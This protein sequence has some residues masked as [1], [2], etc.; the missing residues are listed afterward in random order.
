VIAP[1][2]TVLHRAYGIG[3]EMLPAPQ[4][5]LFES[6]ARA[7]FTEQTLPWRMVQYGAAIGIALLDKDSRLM[8]SNPALQATLGYTGHELDGMALSELCH[9][10]DAPADFDPCSE[11]IAGASDYYRAEKRFDRKD[12]RL[13]WANVTA[14]LVRGTG[15]EPQFVICMVEDITQ[16][17]Q[18]QAALLRAERLAIAGKLAASLAHEINNPLQSVIGCLGLAEEARVEG[19][20]VGRYLPVALEELRRVARIV[21]RLRNLHRP[22]Q[23]EERVPADVNALLERVLAL[24]RKKCEDHGVEVIWREDADL[25]SILLVPDRMQQVFLNLVLNALDAMPGGGRL[26]VSAMHTDQPAGVQVTF[27]DTGAGIAPGVLPRIFDLFYSTKADGLGL[28]LSISQDIVKQ[29]GGK[30]EVESQ[31]G[32]GT[33]FAVWLP[34]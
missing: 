21:A 30:I 29:H 27:T 32:E 15:G 16:R 31:L 6:I 12:D 2:L 33:A 24:S 23:P 3:S 9:P 11:L 26:E 20:D 4:A 34:A 25:P 22:S 1:T 17:K 5:R 13:V 10:D 14:S 28:G 7:M 8:E 19:G 18:A